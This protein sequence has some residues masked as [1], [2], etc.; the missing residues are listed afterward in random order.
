MKVLIID[1]CDSFTSFTVFAGGGSNSYM[2]RQGTHVIYTQS[3]DWSTFYAEL[4]RALREMAGARFDAI[5]AIAQGG[6]IPAAILQQEW[7]IP[8]SIIR[9][10]YRD[11]ENKPRFDDAQR[12]TKGAAQGTA[13]ASLFLLSASTSSRVTV[14][15]G[16]GKLISDE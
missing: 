6:V 2:R 7:G 8:L 4:D 10:T 16:P 5:A 12:G 14:P 3:I 9:I 13:A 1:N 11:N 15:S